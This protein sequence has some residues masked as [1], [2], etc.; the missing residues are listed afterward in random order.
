MGGLGSH[1][2]ASNGQ[3]NMSSV[4]IEVDTAPNRIHQK[5]IQQTHPL[6]LQDSIQTSQTG[7]E[8]QRMC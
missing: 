3:T 6:G 4:E 2:D 1:T 5:Q 8:T 7:S